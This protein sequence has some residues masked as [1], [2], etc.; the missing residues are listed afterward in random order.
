MGGR[1]IASTLDDGDGK[2]ALIIH[3]VRE[4]DV[5]ISESV[6]PV[7]SRSVGRLV[8]CYAFNQSISAM[9]AMSE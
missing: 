4:F 7:N 2:N 6:C 1:R 9:S 5:G 3:Q 8:G